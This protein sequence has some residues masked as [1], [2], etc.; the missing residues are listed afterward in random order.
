MEHKI[1]TPQHARELYCFYSMEEIQKAY[2]VNWIE[3]AYMLLHGKER[4]K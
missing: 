4:K 3:L 1:L 2:G